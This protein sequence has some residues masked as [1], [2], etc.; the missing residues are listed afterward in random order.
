MSPLVLSDGWPDGPP[1]ERVLVDVE[2][3]P[4]GGA[5]AIAVARDEL[6][7]WAD[8]LEDDGLELV[9]TGRRE[10]F[11]LAPCPVCEGS[12]A[13]DLPVWPARDGLAGPA[14]GPAPACESCAGTGEQDGD[15]G[16]RYRQSGPDEEGAVEFWLLEV[17]ERSPA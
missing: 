14:E 17:R 7:G 15:E 12:G 6:D 9:A 5:A 2:A 11:R 3:A 13:D 4:A 10:W 1:E 16:Y 8:S